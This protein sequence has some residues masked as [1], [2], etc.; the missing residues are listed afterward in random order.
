MI[1]TVNFKALL[2]VAVLAFCT[3]TDAKAQTLPGCYFGRGCLGGDLPQWEDSMVGTGINVGS[4]AAS[5]QCA[6]ADDCSTL[7]DAMDSVTECLRNAK[8]ICLEANGSWHL[9]G[10]LEYSPFFNG[11]LFIVQEY[12]CEYTQFRVE[13]SQ[14]SKF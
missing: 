12:Y 13:T 4:C 8:A 14:H 5:I 2:A 3:I 6:N 7:E 9:L 10:P 1:Y 11:D